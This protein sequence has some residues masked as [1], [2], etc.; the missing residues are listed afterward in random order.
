MISKG[1]TTELRTVEQ[2]NRVLAQF[3]RNANVTLLVR[4]GGIQTF[5]TIKASMATNDRQLTL[6][7]HLPPSLP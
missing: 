6:L 1:L 7:A 5:V 3:D 2:F 4:R